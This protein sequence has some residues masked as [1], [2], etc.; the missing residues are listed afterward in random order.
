VL[1]NVERRIYAVKW[2]GRGSCSDLFQ[3]AML[4][5]SLRTTRYHKHL[6]QIN[7]CSVARLEGGTNRLPFELIC[8]VDVK[9]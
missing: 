2:K 9:S 4:T 6:K 5:F 1:N 7:K 8:W 3:N